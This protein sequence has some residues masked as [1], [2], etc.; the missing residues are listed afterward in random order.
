VTTVP[1]PSRGRRR[2]TRDLIEAYALL[3]LLVLAGAFFSVYGKTADAFLTSANLQTLLANQSVLAIVTLA[4]LVPLICGEFDLSVGA[5]AGLASVFTASALS[6]GAPALLGCLLGIA[7]G[8]L[9]GTVNAVLIVR[10]GI[11]A[12]VATLGTAT[13]IAGVIAAKTGGLAIVSDIPRSVT[14]F[15]SGTTLGLPRTTLVL[16]GVAALCAYVL[17]LTPPGRWLHA[18]GANPEAAKLVGLRVRAVKASAFIAAG[19]LAGAAGVL[20]VARAGGADPRTGE[21]FLLP[22][23][24]AAFLSAAAIRPGRFNVGG[25]L[26]AIFF[27]AVLNNGL[28][29]TGAPDYVASFVNGGALLVGVGVGVLLRNERRS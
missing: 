14:D 22:A 17:Y 10:V 2:S 20:Q 24:A 12:V 19:T 3:G 15:G 21:T 7:L 1:R 11:N 28:N 26:V 9:V 23:F 4:I 16:L 29:L 27:L 13:L 8:A 25:V 6:S 18:L 5:T